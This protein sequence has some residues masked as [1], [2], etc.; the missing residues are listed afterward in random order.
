MNMRGVLQDLVKALKKLVEVLV[1]DSRS[2]QHPVDCGK[3][4]TRN[5]PNYR[6]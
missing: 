5:R 3:M 4:L 2:Q 1:E 6:K